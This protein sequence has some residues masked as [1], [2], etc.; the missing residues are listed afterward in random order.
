MAMASEAEMIERWANVLEKA[1]ELALAGGRVA[2]MES[3]A[4]QQMKGVYI[5]QAELLLLAGE[6]LQVTR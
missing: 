2:S 5:A 6:T 3:E 1:L 4:V